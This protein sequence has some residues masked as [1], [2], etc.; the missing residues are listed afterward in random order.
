MDFSISEAITK[1]WELTKKY[2]WFVI[3]LTVVTMLIGQLSPAIDRFI[4]H[5]N[6]HIYSPILTF[7]SILGSLLSI[8]VTIGMTIAFLKLYD[9][10]KTSIEDV[11][12]QYKYFLPYVGGTV[13]YGIIVLLGLILLILPGIFLG[14][15]LQFYKYLILDE[16]LNPV[17]ALKRSWSITEGQVWHLIGYSLSVF[18]VLILGALALGI[19]LLVAIPTIT[20]SS[21]HVYRTLATA[22]VAETIKL[23]KTNSKSKT[24][25]SK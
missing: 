15:R 1:G 18:G 11:F 22:K 10:K 5:N 17:H 24:K 2:L 23:A 12:S 3:G 8:F 9:G 13:L 4:T 19:G 16:N 6:P 14:V 7:T 25:N 21:I 20:F